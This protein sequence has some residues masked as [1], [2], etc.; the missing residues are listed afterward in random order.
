MRVDGY[1]EGV[2]RLSREVRFLRAA[3]LLVGAA[4]LLGVG[5]L[6]FRDNEVRVEVMY[7]PGIDRDFWVSSKGFSKSYLERMGYF[8]AYALL[9]VTPETVEKQA[10]MVVPYLAPQV[11]GAFK[12]RA[13]TMKRRLAEHG[14]SLAF[15]PKQVWLGKHDCRIRVD[16]ELVVLVGSEKARR[17]PVSLNVRCANVNGRFYVTHLD[18]GRD[19]VR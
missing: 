14:V 4:A 16:G 18:Y 9:N 3:L 2:A 1:R 17:K 7:P 8:L 10:E 13:E 19:L 5:G 15:E 12:V 11:R 6:L